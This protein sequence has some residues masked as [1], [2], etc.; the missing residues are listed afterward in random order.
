MIPTITFKL[1]A[2]SKQEL[3]D[4]GKHFRAFMVDMEKAKEGGV[5]G[6][7]SK[8][9]F[10]VLLETE[11]WREKEEKNGPGSPDQSRSPGVG[12]GGAVTR[13]SQTPP[14]PLQGEDSLLPPSLL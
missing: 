1:E 7:P 13:D 4:L 3:I 14:E 6:D 2:E 9:E 5:F 10:R 11:G 8:V 12:G